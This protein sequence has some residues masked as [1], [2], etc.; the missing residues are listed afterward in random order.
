MYIVVSYNPPGSC[1]L[2]HVDYSWGNIMYNSNILRSYLECLSD[3]EFTG[4]IKA[5]VLTTL[6]PS[7]VGGLPGVV[8]YVNVWTDVGGTRER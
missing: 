5:K 2:I 7:P 4:V 1:L 6:H 3:C 8:I